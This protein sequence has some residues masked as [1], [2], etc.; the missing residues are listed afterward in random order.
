MHKHAI[1]R[2]P[3]VPILL[4]IFCCSLSAQDDLKWKILQPSDTLNKT[5]FWLSIGSGATA[6]TA[7]SIGLY[8]TWYKQYELIGFHTFDDLAE[9]NQMDKAGHLLTAYV[10][11]DFAFNI[12]RWTGMKRR[13]ALWTSVGISTLLQGTVEVMDGYSAKWGFSWSDVGFNAL[14]TAS[15]AVQELAWQEQRIR[16]KVSS[17]A[18]APYSTEPI[19]STNGEAATTPRQ[20][21]SQLFGPTYI[22]GFL[23]DYN[24]MTVWASI[25]INAFRKRNDGFP[26]WLNLAIGYGSQNLYGGFENRWTND[27]GAEFVLNNE[28]FPRYRQFYLS[29]DI[30]LSRIKTR[31]RVL[32]T[33][34]KSINWIKIPAPAL[35]LNTQG[36]LRLHPV[37]W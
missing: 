3:L 21:A 23:K 30:D 14:G 25:N 8:H 15:F 7:A 4:L 16:F 9:W 32:R 27:D 2:L 29:L 33:I 22:E 34:F 13:S 37:F 1:V 10:E 12:L 5:R 36:Q 18:E 28:A 35:E 17:L 31:S 20:R 11:T 24:A 6:Y 26:D 19:I